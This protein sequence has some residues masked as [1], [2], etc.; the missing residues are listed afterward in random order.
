MKG[1]T[2]FILGGARSGKSTFALKEASKISGIKAFIATA[3][4]LDE[5]MKERIENHKRQ[6]GDDW[7]TYEEP[8]KIADVIKKIEERYHAVVVDC[9]TLWL[10]NLMKAKFNIEA[11]IRHFISSL[12]TCHSSLI[13]IVSNEVGMG[14]VPENDIARRFRDLAGLLNRKVAEVANEVYMVVAG[15]PLKIKG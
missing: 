15:F 3:E 4:A 11:E 6:R 8:I 9:L 1:K 10:S 14:I 13:F 5:E 7:D 12:R 2:I